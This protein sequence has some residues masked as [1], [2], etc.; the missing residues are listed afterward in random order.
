MSKHTPGPWRIE[1]SQEDG[2]F[3][4]VAD[5]SKNWNNPVVCSFYDDVTP[6]DSICGAEY[7]S[8]PNAEANARLIAAAPDL[9][10]ALDDLESLVSG[11]LSDA[12]S[13]SRGIPAIVAARAAIAKAKGE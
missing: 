2:L 11:W 6:E 13:P 1:G 4:I 3:Y 7:E 5:Q 8:Y 12:N 9:F 10:K